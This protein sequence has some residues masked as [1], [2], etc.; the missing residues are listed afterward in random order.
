MMQLSNNWHDFMAK[1]DRLRPKLDVN[2]L[3]RAQQFSFDYDSGRIPELAYH[4]AANL[5]GFTGRKVMEWF[6]KKTSIAGVQI[7]NWVVALA[8]VLVILLVYSSMH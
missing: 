2:S 5:G 4:E 7:P 3:G 6:S 1:L 8:A